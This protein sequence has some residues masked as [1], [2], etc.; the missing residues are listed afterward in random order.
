ME[1]NRSSTSKPKP[2]LHGHAR[3]LGPGR[4]PQQTVRVVSST[5]GLD[6]L[7]SSLQS[8]SVAGRTWAGNLRVE[9]ES[10]S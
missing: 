9:K 7:L 6:V 2:A 1:P 3:C 4:W 5:S 10:G 8:G